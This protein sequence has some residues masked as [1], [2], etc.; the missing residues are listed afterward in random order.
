[1]EGFGQIVIIDEF[2]I[3]D[4]GVA[5]DLKRIGCEAAAFSSVDSYLYAVRRAEAMCLLMDVDAIVLALRGQGAA[6]ARYEV[7]VERIA[8]SFTAQ[9]R[10]VPALIFADV[11]FDSALVR[12][13]AELH[14]ALV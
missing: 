6:A 9:R 5:A 12:L 10:D 11:G 13:A 7:T 1:M 14:A 3:W 4:E 2:G 8:K